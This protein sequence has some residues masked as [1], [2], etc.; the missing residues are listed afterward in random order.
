VLCYHTYLHSAS[1]AGFVSPSANKISQRNLHSLLPTFVIREREP[2]GLQTTRFR[3]FVVKDLWSDGTGTL[4]GVVNRP[5]HCRSS[6]EA[7]DLAKMVTDRR[8]T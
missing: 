7:C 2:L 5:P 8:L 1:K 6:K 3:R 4:L